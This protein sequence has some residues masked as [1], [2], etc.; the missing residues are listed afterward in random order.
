MFNRLE[1]KLEHADICI[2]VGFAFRHRE[3]NRMINNALSRKK[4][5]QLFVLSRAPGEAIRRLVLRR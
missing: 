5:F 1:N 3:I 4:P 2:V